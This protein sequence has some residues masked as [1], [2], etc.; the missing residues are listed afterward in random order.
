MENLTDSQIKEIGSFSDRYKVELKTNS[1]EWQENL[2]DHKDHA[3][4]LSQRLSK[5]NIDGLN[6]NTF[7][8][9]WKFLWASNIWGNKDWYIDNKLLKPNGLENVKEA[10][11]DLLY[12]EES[13]DH[14]YDTFCNKIKGFGASSISEILNFVFPEKYCLWNAT[15]RAVL[16]Y[17]GIKILPDKFLKYNISTGKE[18]LQVLNVLTII[19]NQLSNFGFENPNFIDLDCLFW[20][21]FKNMVH[22][23]LVPQQR[24]TEPSAIVSIEN[25]ISTHE[26]A[27]YYLIRLG[28][29][30]GYKTYTADPSKD[31]EGTKL[32]EIVLLDTIP[33]SIG[34]RDKK[35]VR[36][37][38]II[39]F[40][41]DDAPKVCIE[42]EN[43]TD[44]SRGLLRLYQLK[45]F[46]SS[47]VIVAPDDKRTK[48]Q[49]EVNKAP[50]REVKERYKFLSYSELL[51][52]YKNAEKIAALKQKLGIS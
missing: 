19:K 13:I 49:I 18:Y 32:G 50:Y 14:R 12:G 7:R 39:W 15:P 20:Y 43:T 30:L 52:L 5:E 36:E 26:G 33:D 1:S 42:V 51:E 22:S 4:F 10:L 23:K 47:F 35:S 31:F 46:Y 40:S 38:D 28:N 24:I 48:F 21:I 11:K 44:V 27:E 45:Q 25:K 41:Y 9:M 29:L 34:E 37:I 3:E 2:K 17:L 16:P 6:E 8:D